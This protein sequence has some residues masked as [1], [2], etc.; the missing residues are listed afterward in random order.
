MS[1]HIGDI[2]TREATMATT[3]NYI[4]DL[5]SMRQF[6]RS[7]TFGNHNR[8]KVNARGIKGSQHDDIIRRLDYFGI[9]PHMYTQRIGKA[10]IHHLNKDDFID[11]YNYLNSLYELY[12]AVPEQI[13]VQLCILAE[14][15]DNDELTIVNLNEN[16][17]LDIYVEHYKDLVNVLFKKRNK[18]QTPPKDIDQ[19]YIQ[20]QVKTLETIGI[21]EKTEQSK[22]YSYALKNTIIDSLT[23]QQL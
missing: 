16:I 1:K 8:G 23:K 22:G 6:I 15:A 19:Q 17:N 3:T 7:L 20:R 5:A 13:F 10:S 2:T 9:I 21:I 4:Q 12:A 18:K 14:L 11:G